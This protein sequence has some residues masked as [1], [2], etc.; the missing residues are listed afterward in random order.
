MPRTGRPRA[1]PSTAP[2][3][4]VVMISLI[5]LVAVAMNLRL[6]HRRSLRAIER[7]LADSDPSLT[8]LFS[9]FTVL[10]PGK[11]RCRAEKVMARPLRAGAAAGNGAR[12][13]PRRPL[14][15]VEVAVDAQ[16]EPCRGTG[17]DAWARMNSLSGITARPRQDHMTMAAEPPQSPVT[18]AVRSLEVR[19]ICPGRLEAQV[20]GWFARFPARMEL[21]E[22]IYLLEPLWPGCRSRSAGAGR[23]R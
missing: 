16:R 15:T 21:R 13:R 3:R 5:Q 7:D 2:A 18:E 20:A 12:I 10:A 9:T 11:E 22:D 4:A 23:C 17:P 8:K 14:A 1:G 19:W 6:R